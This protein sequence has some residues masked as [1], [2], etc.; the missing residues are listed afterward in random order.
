MTDE[1]TSSVVSRG[2]TAKWNRHNATPC[3]SAIFDR[4]LESSVQ[5]LH[6]SVRGFARMSVSASSFYEKEARNS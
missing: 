1:D 6:G 4:F 3:S 5:V 2:E